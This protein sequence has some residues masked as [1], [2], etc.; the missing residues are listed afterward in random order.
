MNRFRSLLFLA[1]TPALVY[2]NP[3]AL[4]HPAYMSAERLTVTL[5]SDAAEMDGRFHFKSLATPTHP[6][7]MANVDLNVPIW[8]PS[9]PK[10][11]DLATAHFLRTFS[12]GHLHKLNDSN[13]EIWDAA[14]RLRIMVG[15]HPLQIERFSILDPRD[16]NDRASI[17]AQWLRK[18]YYCL[19]VSVDFRS[20]WLAGDPE[21]MVTYRQ[22]HKQSKGEYEFHYVPVFWQLPEELNTRD[23]SRY[24]M[25]LNNQSGLSASLGTLKIHQGQSAV[26]PLSHHEPVTVTIGED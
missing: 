17:P 3:L 4:W 10:R 25:R 16:K 11:T 5:R 23:L 9:D 7:A 22:G 20:D 2:S 24:S 15:T 18:G 12:S 21:I 19:N 13:C 8:I 1:C 6:G 26:L 14:I